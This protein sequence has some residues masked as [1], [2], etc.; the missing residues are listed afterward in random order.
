MTESRMSLVEAGE[1]LG[2]QPNS[3]RSRWKN[4]KI[5]G[6]R[7]N[8]GKIWVWIDKTEAASDKGSNGT[9][10]KSSIEGF[11]NKALEVAFTALSDQLEAAK[12]EI[13]QLRPQA[14]EA[15]TLR[16]ENAGLKALA[17]VREAVQVKTDA[18]IE[19]LRASLEKV[20]AEKRELI[21]EVLKSK[22]G[23]WARIFGN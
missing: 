7:D 21:E 18:E 11:E 8:T 5:R 15:T 12:A 4:N 20:D 13:D 6:E 19:A 16:A 10:S 2:I 23:L 14:I 1:V 17:E 3:V 22:R 9:P